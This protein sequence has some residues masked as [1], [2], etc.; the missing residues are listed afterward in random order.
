MKCCL[1]LNGE[2]VW[3]ARDIKNNF[4]P[5]SLR[6]YYLGGSLLVWLKAN[7]GEEEAK[8]LEETGSLE[9]AFGVAGNETL[10]APTVFT[11]VDKICPTLTESV[12]AKRDSFPSSGS[13]GSFGS[14]SGSSSGS[15]GYG[16]HII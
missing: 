2:R 8:K 16:L 11:N 9:Y 13:F 4:D 15:L 10:F 1:W 5:T 7:D 12:G 3:N 14:G 6:G